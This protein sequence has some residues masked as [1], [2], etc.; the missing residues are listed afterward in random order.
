MIFSSNKQ[1]FFIIVILSVI[2][3]NVL[4]QSSVTEDASSHTSE[5]E[6]ILSSIRAMRKELDLLQSAEE[7]LRRDPANF[8]HPAVLSSLHIPVPIAPETPVRGEGGG[9]AGLPVHREEEPHRLPPRPPPRAPAPPAATPLTVADTASSTSIMKDIPMP[10][11]Y[12]L[13]SSPALLQR[14]LLRPSSLAPLPLCAASGGPTHDLVS[15]L[16]PASSASSSSPPPALSTDTDNILV[17][18]GT[19]GSGTR[20]VVQLLTRL[21]VT[22]VSEDPE[23]FDLHAD[24]LGGWPEVVT[25][26]LAVSCHA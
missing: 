16:P 6:K 5:E 8:A 22:V 23:T 18:G 20:R 2:V 19:D 7:L 4:L 17:V 1:A 3:I 9:G 10:G 14:I 11:T 15:S 21:G 24:L 26:V 12:M 25:P 13:H